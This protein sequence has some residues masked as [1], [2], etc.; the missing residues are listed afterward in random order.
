[1]SLRRELRAQPH[2]FDVLKVLRELERSSPHKPRIGESSVLAE[3]IV[4]LGQDPFLAFPGSNISGYSEPES[5]RPRL[6]AR[7]LGYFG[8]Q[9]ALPLSTTLEAYTWANQRDPSFARFVNIFANRFLQLFFRAW[10]D[11]RPIAQHD[12]PS[13]DRFLRYVGAFAGLGSD[14][15]LGRD[16]LDDIAKVSFAGLVGPQVKSASRLS[17]LIR[18][19]FGVEVAIEE[20]IGA[21]LVFE[22]EDR[23]VLGARGASLGQDTFL[24]ARS[25]SINEKIR[26]AIKTSGLAQYRDFLPT[27]ALS[28][29]LVDLVFFYLGYRFEFDIELALPARDAPPVR[30]GKSGE[31]GWTSWIAPKSVGPGDETCLSDA[32]FDPMQRRDDASAPRTAGQKRETG[33]ASWSTSASRR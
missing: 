11:A 6:D 12:R 9:G 22:P 29:K 31:L 15:W 7:F 13:E 5:R 26:I 27:G 28:G 14:L 20:R 25:Y 33:E 23:M 8:P 24:G 10:A 3:E 30:L 1:M 16:G 32:R 21:W 17:Q 4:D 2:L 18:G 19:V